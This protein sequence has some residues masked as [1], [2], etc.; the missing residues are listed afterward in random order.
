MKIAF[1]CPYYD[2]A[3]D[4][5]KQAVKELARRLIKDGHEVHVYT[6]DSDKYKRIKKRLQKQLDAVRK[7]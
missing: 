1:I 5:P 7:L 6:S 2:P 3:I 4:G